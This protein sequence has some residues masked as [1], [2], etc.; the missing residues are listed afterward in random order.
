[1]KS[2][3]CLVHFP[4]F[5][6]FVLALLRPDNGHLSKELGVSQRGVQPLHVALPG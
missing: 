3:K 4:E 6:P 1:M 5:P 2:S